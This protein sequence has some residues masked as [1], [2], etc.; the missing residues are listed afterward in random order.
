[1][2]DLDPELQVCVTSL[3]DY[4]KDFRLDSVFKGISGAASHSF[5]DVDGHLRLSAAAVRNLELFQNLVD[6]KEAGTLTLVLNQT[7]T[8][9]GDRLLR[10]VDSA[11]G[12]TMNAL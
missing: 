10:Q 8:K 2:L 6:G 1:L 9:F 11:V 12:R 3:I 5:S 4:L 7:H